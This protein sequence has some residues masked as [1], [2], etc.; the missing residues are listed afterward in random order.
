MMK[1][2]CGSG[3]CRDCHTLSR[4]EAASLLGGLVDNVAR[5]EPAAV[6]GLWVADILKD[7]QSWPVY[8]DF[9]KRFLISGQ[10]YKLSTR[11]DLTDA[12]VVSLN[13]IDPSRVPASGAIVVGNPSA[14]RKIVVFSDPDCP[15]CAH[16]HG[17]LKEV[18]AK[19]P[20]TAFL[21]RIYARN[22]EAAAR[23]KAVA[24]ACDPSGRLLEE[25]YAGR[26]VPA[27]RCKSED[28]AKAVEETEKAV[29]ALGLKGTP[30][31]VLPDGRVVRGYRDAETLSRYIAGEGAPG[32][33]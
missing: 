27:D 12:R 17:E 30:I 21:V 9:S 4:E 18:A 10:V 2:G 16:L 24:I 15:H 31:L 11:E 19:D 26:P 6:K 32:G 33:K 28:A 7:G 8:I 20:G 5:V 13:R 22:G 3:E 29:E 1:E 23:E 14:K 25:A